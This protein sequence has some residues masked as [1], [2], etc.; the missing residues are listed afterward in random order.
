MVESPFVHGRNRFGFAF[1]KGEIR[2]STSWKPSHPIVALGKEGTRLGKPPSFLSSWKCIAR[3]FGI[4]SLLWIEYEL[5]L[6]LRT[7]RGAIASFPCTVPCL[8]AR[9][10]STPSVVT[11]PSWFSS[12]HFARWGSCTVSVHPP[13]GRT[14]PSGSTR[15]LFD[16]FGSCHPPPILPL[17][18]NRCH[19]LWSGA[20]IHPPFVPPFSLHVLPHGHEP[21]CSSVLPPFSLGWEPLILGSS[22]ERTPDGGMGGLGGV[23]RF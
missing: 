10:P 2:R 1:R 19:C 15:P 23:Q 17:L 22:V 9:A 11:H 20:R 18:A 13:E 4:L 7:M 6:R 16:S 3:D 8:G 5:L 21:T 14:V 12:R